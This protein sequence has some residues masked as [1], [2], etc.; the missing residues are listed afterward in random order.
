MTTNALVI[1]IGVIIIMRPQNT[2]MNVIFGPGPKRM[3]N[4]EIIVLHIGGQ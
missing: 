1:T 2:V 4:K 3:R